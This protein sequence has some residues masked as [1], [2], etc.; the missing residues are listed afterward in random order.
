LYAD[1][2]GFRP[3]LLGGTNANA[4][5]RRG[6]R[7]VYADLPHLS[8][9]LRLRASRMSRKLP[10]LTIDTAPFWQGGAQGVLQIHY[11]AGCHRFFHPPNPIC[12][13]CN[14]FDVSPRPVSGRGR[15]VT[16][17]INRQAWTAELVE[18]YV[19]AIVELAEQA[20]LRLLSNIVGCDPDA[21]V[22]DM[23]VSVTFERHEDVWIPL[24]ERAA[25][26]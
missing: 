16:F 14:S 4:D 9:A 3:R 17:T 8:L 13:H 7:R 24:F 5:S 6:L 10:A 12:P 15:V 22:I 1:R 26:V 23:P 18:P 21:V 20:N 19:V 25:D 11:C 2:L